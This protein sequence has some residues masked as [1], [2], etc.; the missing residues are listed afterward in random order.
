MWAVKEAVINCTSQDKEGLHCTDFSHCIQLN[1][2]Q[3]KNTFQIKLT[4]YNKKYILLLYL[5]F[6]Q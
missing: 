3:I 2:E 4:N 1:T 5:V 6:V